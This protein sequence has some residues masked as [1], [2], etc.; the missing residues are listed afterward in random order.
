MADSAQ[1]IRGG[2]CQQM[3]L[4]QFT[5]LLWLVEQEIRQW[6]A[7]VQGVDCFGAEVQWY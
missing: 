3:S 7:D 6:N 4:L 1:L 2:G 5:R